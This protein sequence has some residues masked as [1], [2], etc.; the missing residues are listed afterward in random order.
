MQIS[1][2]DCYVFQQ[3]DPMQNLKAFTKY[4]RNGYKQLILVFS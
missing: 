2:K 3:E 1:K 4:D